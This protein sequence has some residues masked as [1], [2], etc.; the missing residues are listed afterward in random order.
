MR[1]CLLVKDDPNQPLKLSK[2][3]NAQP[4][5]SYVEETEPVVSKTGDIS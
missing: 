1:D 3:G 2:L 5:G 4:E